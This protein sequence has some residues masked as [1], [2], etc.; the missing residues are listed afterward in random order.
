M[1][2]LPCSA[3]GL[4]L[5]A[6]ALLGGGRAKT[7]DGVLEVVLPSRLGGALG[8][9][10]AITFGHVV[11]GRSEY[12]LNRT[13]RHERVHVQQY[14]RWGLLFFIVYPA[15]SFLQWIRGRDPYWFNAFEIEAR[16]RC[17]DARANQMAGSSPMVSENRYSERP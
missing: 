17:R 12:I 8:R 9:F 14:E 13:R 10:G 1:W 11:L 3:V 5:M 4:M 7:R 16:E 6:A 15:S 2:A